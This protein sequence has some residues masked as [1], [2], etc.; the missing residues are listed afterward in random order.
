MAETFAM[1]KSEEWFWNSLP[2]TFVEILDAKKRIEKERLKTLAVYVGC[3]FTG[4]NLNLIDDE[5]EIEGIDKPVSQ[6]ALRSLY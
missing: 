6:D 4:Q 2:K 3:I 1:G 5:K